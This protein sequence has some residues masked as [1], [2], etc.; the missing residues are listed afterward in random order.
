MVI[1]S[2][3]LKER[4][5]SELENSK[6]SLSSEQIKQLT[7]HFPMPAEIDSPMRKNFEENTFSVLKKLNS[8]NRKSFYVN[9][10]N[11]LEMINHI[12]ENA[13]RVSFS[14]VQFNKDKFP[15]KYSQLSKFDGILY[16][17]Y[18]YI[19]EEGN[20]IGGKFYAMHS[21]DK[22]VEISSDDARLMK[23]D[24]IKNI[25]FS[26]DGFV[27]GEQGNTLSVKMDKLE[28]YAYKI[29]LL[30]NPNFDKIKI[31]F[32]QVYNKS[33]IMSKSNNAVQKKAK[34]ISEDSEGQM[35]FVT[36]ALDNNGEVI[37]DLSGNDVNKLCPTICS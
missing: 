28:L 2:C 14:F 16:L 21:I 33:I 18:E 25:K 37:E 27:A 23:N 3:S 36:D 7:A 17:I 34:F 10:K 32:V 13:D 9:K 20:N 35:T 5:S 15:N 26:I 31:T 29:K 19:D 22:I 8:K 11:Y 24:Y 30:N 12:P 6:I 1:N 4:E